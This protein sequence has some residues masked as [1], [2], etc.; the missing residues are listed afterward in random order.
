[1]TDTTE[2]ALR[3]GGILQTLFATGGDLTLK[4][5]ITFL[6]V[7]ANPGHSAREYSDM[8]G[9][10]QATMSRHLLGLGQRKRHRNDGVGLI[11][12]VR[13]P[14]NWRANVHT[15]SPKGLALVNALVKL[16]EQGSAEA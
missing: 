13:N 1:M 3:L 6:T 8:L 4:M 16:F 14:D 15:L 11:I 7:A 5:A 10:S 2:V 9:H 12:A